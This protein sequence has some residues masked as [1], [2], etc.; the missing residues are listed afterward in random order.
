MIR[1]PGAGGAPPRRNERLADASQRRE[2]PVAANVAVVW[3]R[4]RASPRHCVHECDRARLC[5][6]GVSL[7][8]SAGGASALEPAVVGRRPWRATAGAT[9]HRLS[10]SA[11]VRATQATARRRAAAATINP[12][13][14]RAGSRRTRITRSA[15]TLSIGAERNQ[16][17][18]EVD[19][20]A[21]AEAPGIPSVGR[22]PGSSR[23]MSPGLSATS[24]DW[25]S[26]RCSRQLA[27][28]RRE[29]A[30]PRRGLLHRVAG[31]R[32]AVTPPRSRGQ[33]APRW[34]SSWRFRARFHA[35]LGRTCSRFVCVRTRPLTRLLPRRDGRTRNVGGDKD[36]DAV[37]GPRRRARVPERS[38][39]ARSAFSKPAPPMRARSVRLTGPVS[40]L[41]S[42]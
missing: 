24:G 27:G 23:P 7:L 38:N 34:A 16:A 10:C 17:W 13:D 33:M 20:M 22:A 5:L 29:R 1:K 25:P 36:V 4:A 8:R 21:A 2:V 39:R 42:R 12:V 30:R 6:A 3:S 14:R 37:G 35:G 18:G 19:R 26:C 32:A 41:L 31:P 15:P 9:G 11:S 28:M 40:T